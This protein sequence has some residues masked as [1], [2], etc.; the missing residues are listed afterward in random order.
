MTDRKGFIFDP[1]LCVACRSCS[2]A[3]ML[4]NGW[5][6]RVR[7]VFSNNNAVTIPILL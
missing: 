5:E 3:C 2:A 1:A 6:T 4:A 7:T